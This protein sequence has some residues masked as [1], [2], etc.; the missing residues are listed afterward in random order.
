MPVAA[1]DLGGTRFALPRS[2][3]GRS[4]ADVRCPPTRSRCRGLADGD[5]RPGRRLARSAEA[6][7]VAVTG[8]IRDGGWL[9]LNPD[10]LPVPAGLPL[11]AE[12][13]KRVGLPTTTV[14]DGQAA[15]W[16]EFRRGAGQGRGP[17]FYVTASTGIGGGRCGGELLRGQ[18]RRGRE[19]RAYAG[20]PGGAA[21][22]LR[23]IG[24]LEAVASGSALA[25]EAGASAMPH[26]SAPASCGPRSCS[27]ARPRRSLGRS[28]TSRPCSTRSSSLWAAA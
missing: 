10:V 15:A 6:L 16:G 11:A 28:A 23:P 3:T 8:I 18:W 12:L 25:V 7:G 13:T 27:T 20:G 5:G 4:S 22:R 1:I 26:P 2:P 17:S 9:A 21:L 14:N 24:C 19:P